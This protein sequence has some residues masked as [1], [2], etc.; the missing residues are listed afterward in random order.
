MTPFADQQMKPL[1]T[2]VLHYVLP[3]ELELHGVTVFFSQF[4]EVSSLE[5]V[6]GDEL[7]VAVKFF[8][9]RAVAL[10]VTH[11]GLE[12]C[13]P[14]E[15]Q[16]DFY[17]KLPGSWSL[18]LQD[19]SGIAN[20]HEDS[21]EE[22]TFKLEFYDSRDAGR[23][24]RRLQQERG[25]SG[26]EEESVSRSSGWEPEDWTQE[27][28]PSRLQRAPRPVPAYVQA[29]ELVAEAGS[30]HEGA[31]SSLAS[32]MAA[33]VYE[34]DLEPSHIISE[35]PAD[36]AWMEDLVSFFGSPET[37]DV[38][39]RHF[40]NY[41]LDSGSGESCVD[42]FASEE[43]A[44]EVAACEQSTAAAPVEVKTQ[45]DS[46]ESEQ[47]EEDQENCLS[48]VDSS[49]SLPVKSEHELKRWRPKMAKTP[50]LQAVNED[51][52]IQKIR[53]WSG[54]STAEASTEAGTSETGDER[55]EEAAEC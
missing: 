9:V 32:K 25:E 16:G 38:F 30:P 12:R 33:A 36:E 14:V 41:G 7:T 34:D 1:I 15:R 18:A 50:G 51:A 54:T 8:D 29:T 23:F 11:L 22:D 42:R 44:A 19:V 31:L 39:C 20:V 5:L 27:E 55:Q 37:V 52:Y 24:R 45:E 6:P 28:A 3:Q 2:D 53:C 43:A 35:T 46:E 49:G 10:A 4:G 26:S 21:E 40:K 47:K 13:W 17:V 48:S